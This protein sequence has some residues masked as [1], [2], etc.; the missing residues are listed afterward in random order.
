MRVI[1]GSE[2]TGHIVQDRS[3]SNQKENLHGRVVPLHRAK[4]GKIGGGNGEVQVARSIDHHVQDL[5][6]QRNTYRVVRMT[7]F[8]V[9][10]QDLVLLIFNHINTMAMTWRTSPARRKILF[11]Y[12][13]AIDILFK[14]KL[15]GCGCVVDV[16]LVRRDDVG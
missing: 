1:S 5:G 16:R 3:L 2:A 13:T 8:R 12:F 4:T 14:N 9:P 11:T 10:E 6:P 7:I 15:V